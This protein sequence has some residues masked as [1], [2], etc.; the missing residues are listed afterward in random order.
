[1]QVQL[2][3]FYRKR[4]S[5]LSWTENI[6]SSKWKKEV[7]SFSDKILKNYGLTLILIMLFSPS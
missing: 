2:R 3:H 4:L 7:I 6:T 1:M 5:R